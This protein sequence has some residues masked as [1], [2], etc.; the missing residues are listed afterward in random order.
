MNPEH[1]IL[2][3]KILYRYL[4]A[5]LGA[6]VFLYRAMTDLSIQ[7]LENIRVVKHP[8]TFQQKLV[9]SSITHLCHKSKI[10]TT[11]PLLITLLLLIC[12]GKNSLY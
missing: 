12:F 4:D 2:I 6:K 5:L 3:Q 1:P 8:S 9:L 7:Q 10:E 11:M